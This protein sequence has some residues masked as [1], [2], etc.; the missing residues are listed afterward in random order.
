MDCS[1]V[2]DLLVSLYEGVSKLQPAH[3]E[4][5]GEQRG[6]ARAD[7]LPHFL[8][9]GN[10]LSRYLNKRTHHLKLKRYDTIQAQRPTNLRYALRYLE[11]EQ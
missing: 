4:G 6:S 5:D 7:Y 11:Y 3:A 10:T 1:L 2:L 8:R 9:F